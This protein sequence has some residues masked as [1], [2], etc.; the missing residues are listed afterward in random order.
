[1]LSSGGEDGRD[2]AEGVARLFRFL[3]GLPVSGSVGGG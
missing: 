1:M 3:D 2:T